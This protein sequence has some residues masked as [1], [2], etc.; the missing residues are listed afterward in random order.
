MKLTNI[1]EN[2]LLIEQ[3]QKESKQLLRASCDGLSPDQRFVIEGI[4][5]ELTPLIEASLSPDQIKQIFQNLEQQ[6]VAG[7]GSKNL[8][9]KGIDVAKQANDTINKIGKWLQNTTPVKAFDQKF[10]DLKNKIN[11]KFPDSKLLDKISEMGMWAKENPGKT[12]AIIGVLTA[13]ASLAGGPVG[14]AIAGQILKGSVELL[15]G[16]KLSTAIGKGAKAAALGWLTGK[17]VQFIG[18]ALSDPMMSQANE[19][20]RGIVSANYRATID[21]IGGEFGSRFGT[22]TTGQLYGKAEDIADIKDVWKAG[23]DAWKAGDYFRS[24]S[25]FKAAGEMTAK[26]SDP[27][28]VQEIASTVEKAKEMAAAAKEMKG[29]FDTMST[30]AQGAATG[31]AS[32]DKKE[33]FYLQTR[34]LSEGQVYLVFENVLAEAGFLDKVKSG[35]A[36]AAGAVAK[37]A[38]WAGKQATEKVTSAKLMAAWKINGSPTDSEELKKFL[39]DYDGMD[40]AIVDKVYADMNIASEPEQPATKPQGAEPT[41]SLYANT[42]KQVLTLNNKDK[43]R[44]MVYL[45]KQL[46]TP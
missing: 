16:E 41:G 22:F 26:L 42:K 19:M 35:A 38:S 43:Q 36:K 13:I 32:K 4:Y 10:E 6:S 15:K 28:Y 45:K 11:T 37:G 18:N 12:A 21:E 7:G 29:F 40:P 46:G 20:G 25:M 44:I 1:S 34:P 27:A 30:V 9:G 8:L 5:K 39:L 17:A 23:V 14:G 33:S 24:D 2:I 31:A 3:H